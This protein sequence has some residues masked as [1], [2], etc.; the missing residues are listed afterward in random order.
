[1]FLSVGHY[2]LDAIRRGELSVL[3]FLVAS[4]AVDSV[5]QLWSV[6]GLRQGSR[7]AP[8]HGVIVEGFAIDCLLLL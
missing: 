1:M 3:P 2:W 6:H 5:T 8:K 4:L 7:V